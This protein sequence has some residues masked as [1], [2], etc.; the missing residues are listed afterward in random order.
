VSSCINGDSD[1]DKGKNDKF[2][3]FISGMPG[4]LEQQEYALQRPPKKNSFGL[5]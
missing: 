3:M 1:N 5:Q 2:N 4:A